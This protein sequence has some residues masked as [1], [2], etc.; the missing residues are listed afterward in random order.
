M[1]P[2]STSTGLD[3]APS[4]RISSL[5]DPSLTASLTGPISDQGN[6]GLSTAS[7]VIIGVTIP[8][9]L[10]VLAIAIIWR[11]RG[12]GANTSQS[13]YN[14]TSPPSLNVISP[15][16]EPSSASLISPAAS[17]RNADGVPLTPPPRLQE[18]RYISQSPTQSSPERVSS[19]LHPGFHIPLSASASASASS[20]TTLPQTTYSPVYSKPST[21]EDPSGYSTAE[22]QGSAS[23]PATPVTGQFSPRLGYTT[24]MGG[25]PGP[26]PDRALPNRPTRAKTKATGGD[27]AAREPIPAD[28][29]GVALD[30]PPQKKTKNLV[31]PISSNRDSW[32]TLSVSDEGTYHMA[33]PSPSRT[34]SERSP[35]MNERDLERLGG[36]Y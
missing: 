11:L 16:D 23:T 18:R 35:I 31:S 24:T 14:D 17:Y 25:V 36:T 8:V 21:A 29:I 20:G 12:R 19:R 32:G 30:F 33:M 10:I 13:P 3:G 28:E 4:P 5:E 27:W 1:V 26:P 34:K 6:P 7:K 15:P 9:A 22:K 2:S